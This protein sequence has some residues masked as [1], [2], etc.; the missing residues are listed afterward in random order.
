MSEITQIE[1][2][3]DRILLGEK[4]IYLVGTAHISQASVE[5]AERVIREQAPD[6]VAIEL[7][8][9]RHASLLDPDRWKNTDI[10][11][12]IRSGKA[13]VLMAQLALASFQKK[14]GDQLQVKPGSEMI[15]SARV[16][17]EIGAELLLADRDVR[18]TL[19]RSWSALGLF[20]TFRLIMSMIFG[21]FSDQKIDEEEIERL[22]KSDALEEVMKEFSEAL[23]EVR[24][25]L[26]DERDQYLAAKIREGDAKTVVAIVGA[27]HVPG[28]KQWIDKEIDIE[29]LEVIP[30]PNPVWKLIGWLI[31][32]LV[33]S[34][35]AYGFSTSGASKTL[36]MA[37]AWF[38]VNGV[39]GAL[40]SLLA[41]AHPVTIFTAF[42]ASPFTS[43]N[44][45]IAGGWVA[46]IVEALVRKPQVSD[47]ETI[48]DDISHFQ[49][50]WKNRVSRILLVVV[51]TNLFG[52]LGTLIGIERV[53]SLVR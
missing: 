34:L 11:S 36:E 23:P 3:V 50:I 27:G 33:L 22:K 47:L 14:L 52:T 7:C 16:A 45:M 46:G 8:E 44:P 21:L 10:L 13:Y 2:N 26:I 19:K 51:L 53:S 28:I 31:P 39:F 42:V 4:T 43:L 30:Q 12:V 20:G 24:V 17:D 49:G 18:T 48:A 38:L 6:A 32:I 41:L 35:F 40:G 25:A 1:E 29:A 5:L 37:T 9:G 15:A